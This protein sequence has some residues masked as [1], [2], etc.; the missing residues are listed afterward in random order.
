ME[1]GMAKGMDINGLNA[2][3]NAGFLLAALP[4]GHVLNEGLGDS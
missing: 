2:F 3:T 1:L 4:W